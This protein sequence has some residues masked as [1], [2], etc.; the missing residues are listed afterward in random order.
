M[1]HTSLGG[2]LYLHLAGLTVAHYIVGMSIF[3]LAEKAGSYLLRNA[4]V[5]HLEAV[6]SA[7]TA[8]LRIKD[9]E[10]NARYHL[11]EL[12]AVDGP[13]EPFHMARGMIS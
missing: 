3:N 9:N 13:S 2:H 10:I 4:I 6:G 12:G 11:D 1:H 8:A 7:Y 5:L